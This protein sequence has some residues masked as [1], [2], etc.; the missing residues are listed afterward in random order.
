MFFSFMPFLKGFSIQL[1]FFS[2]FFHLIF[3][4]YL[5][6]EFTAQDTQAAEQYNYRDFSNY[7]YKDLFIKITKIPFKGQNV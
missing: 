7:S 5:H 2:Y 3:N 6:L 1:L 4:P